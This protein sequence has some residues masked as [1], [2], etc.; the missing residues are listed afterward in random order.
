[1]T[2]RHLALRWLG[3]RDREERKRLP[4]TA[5]Y[6]ALGVPACAAGSITGIEVVHGRWR[7]AAAA[8]VVAA[9]FAVVAE[10]YRDRDLLRDWR[11]SRGRRLAE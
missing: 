6:F 5:V 4:R 8:F 11:R 9:I 10:G 1:M 7:A 3:V 2:V